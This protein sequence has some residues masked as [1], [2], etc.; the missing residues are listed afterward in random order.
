MSEKTTKKKEFGIGSVK[1]DMNEES[2]S[3]RGMYNLAIGLT[4]VAG[5]ALN[6]L[7]SKFLSPSIS[8][9]LYSNSKVG[10]ILILVL[11]LVGSFAG[12]AIV[13]KVQSPAVG[14]LGFGLL[15]FAMGLVLSVILPLYTDV[16]IATAF[17]ITM[18]ITAVMT[19]AGAL[20]P[21]FF[22][23]IGKG[24][25]ITL[26]ITIIAELLCG[27]VFFRG[28]N[29]QIFDYIVIFIFCGYIGFD[30]SRAQQR[31]S[32]INNAIRSAAAIYVDVVN[33]FIRVLSIIGKRRD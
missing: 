18:V 29:L 11:Y 21:A 8:D 32:T 9:Y 22:S 10:L 25:C 30:W 28:R 26:L 17:L 15:A 20:F 12:I 27:L 6:F 4:V 13:N 33:I 5:C 16:S 14:I 19:V 7:M 2:T 24:L 31:P 1:F 3:S 23:S